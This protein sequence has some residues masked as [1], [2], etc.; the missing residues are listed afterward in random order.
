MTQKDALNEARGLFESHIK[1]V[2]EEFKNL[3]GPALVWTAE[4]SQWSILQI[5]D[6]LVVTQKSYIEKMRAAIGAAE[7]AQDDAPYSPTWIGRTLRKAAGPGGNAPAP[8][9]FHPRKNPPPDVFDELIHQWRELMELCDACQ[10]KAVMRPVI[11]TPMS[12]VP[13]MSVVDAL[14]LHAD[15]GSRHVGQMGDRKAA[16][17]PAAF[18]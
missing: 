6:H 13:K 14:L 9:M 12:P 5:A 18:A 8:K 11:P 17:T 4:P 10:G 1:R 15:H 2:A 16:Q 7:A 3:D